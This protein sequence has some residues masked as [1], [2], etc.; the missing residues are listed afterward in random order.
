MDSLFENGYVGVMQ[1][2]TQKEWSKNA[3]RNL[4]MV[5][6]R[7]P[8]GLVTLYKR[9]RFIELIESQHGS[10]SGIVIYLQLKNNSNN[11]NFNNPIFA[12]NNIHLVGDPSKFEAHEK[13]LNGAYKNLKLGEKKIL[14]IN[15]QFQQFHQI[16]EFICGDFNGDVILIEQQQSQEEQQE[17]QQQESQR[18]TIGNWFLNNGFQRVPT[19]S[20]W[21]NNQ[22]I[23]RLDHIMFNN[24]N[25]NENCSIII[26]EYFPF[27]DEV[28]LQTLPNGLPN[29]IH[30][31]DHL[32]IQ[33]D[34]D[35]IF[36]ENNN[37]INNDNNNEINN[38][39]I[40]NNNT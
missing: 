40:N 21:A 15:N 6:R 34:F 26:K 29:E 28:A 23:S 30:P 24:R 4:K 3:D 16:Y 39:N 35:F 31:S 25:D 2:M 14:E 27:N 5:G 18:F 11:N 32:M 7:E 9:G 13:Q 19:G 36:S 37:G 10:G 22:T 38:D 33:V 17:S 1:K 8:T 20:S 12:I